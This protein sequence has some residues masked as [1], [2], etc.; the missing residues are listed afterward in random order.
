MTS[1]DTSHMSRIVE[2]NIDALLRRRKIEEKKKTSEERI[3]DSITRFTGSMLFVYIH[4]VLFVGW[5]VWNSGILG[6]PPFD[7]SFVI[8]AMFA[9]V[10]A[11]FLSTFVLISQNRMN[12]QADKR[13]EL[14][15]QITLLAEHE[16]TRL[17]SITS[18]IAKKMDL[19]VPEDAPELEKDIRPEKVL[20]TLDKFDPKSGKEN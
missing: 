11:I 6:L 5:I 16:I 2:R 10:E 8:L 18:A 1:K 12:V 9:S 17:I 13:A 14:D 7:E 15:L 20:D 19:D 4:L 3:A